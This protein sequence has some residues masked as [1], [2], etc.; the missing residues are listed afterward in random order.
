MTGP[1]DMRLEGEAMPV[2]EGLPHAPMAMP[3]QRL[4][5]QPALW[6]GLLRFPV[7]MRSRI[8]VR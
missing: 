8:R 6:R 7:A 4:E 3:E 2:E 1:V 5:R